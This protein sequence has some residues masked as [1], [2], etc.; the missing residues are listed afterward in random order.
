MFEHAQ[1]VLHTSSLS[2]HSWFLP[3]SD[4]LLMYQLPHPLVLL[5]NPP[6]KE[7]FKKLVK[8][9][10]IDYWEQL[11]KVK[12]AKPLEKGHNVTP[13]FNAGAVQGK[14]LKRQS[15]KKSFLQ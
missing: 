13:S 12:T 6:R 5:A 8:A 15:Q 4:I 11:L 14:N 1:N 2:K 7:A 10:V 3:I 9:K